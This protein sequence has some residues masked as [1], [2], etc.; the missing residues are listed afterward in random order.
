[1]SKII[2]VL[3]SEI[4]WCYF[5][6]R[7]WTF[8]HLLAVVR[9]MEEVIEA[10]LVCQAQHLSKDIFGVMLEKGVEENVTQ[11]TVFL[12][13]VLAEVHEPLDV[14]VGSDEL[15]ILEAEMHCK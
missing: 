13:L 10:G 7:K 5:Y 6:R 9:W 2:F 14:K 8:P 15:N 12:S 11:S 1:M 3:H 4:L